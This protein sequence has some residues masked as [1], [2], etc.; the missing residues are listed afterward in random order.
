[1][2]HLTGSFGTVI[3]PLAVGTPLPGQ[4]SLPAALEALALC[5]GIRKETAEA[6]ADP[7][8]NHDPLISWMR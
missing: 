7:R 5:G 8:H 1:M 6:F 2:S 4:M 3:F